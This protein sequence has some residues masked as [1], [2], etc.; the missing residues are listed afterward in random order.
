MKPRKASQ[1]VGAN[2]ERPPNALLPHWS[3]TPRSGRYWATTPPTSVPPH[4]IPGSGRAPARCGSTATTNR[5]STPLRSACLRAEVA[6]D[7]GRVDVVNG[8]PAEDEV[9]VPSHVQ[10]VTVGT[11]L[12]DGEPTA[13]PGPVVR[14]VPAVAAVAAG[15]ALPQEPGTGVGRTYGTSWH[16]QHDRRPWPMGAT[17]AAGCRGGVRTGQSAKAVA[18]AAGA[19]AVPVPKVPQERK[20]LPGLPIARGPA[21]HGPLRR[22]PLTRRGVGPRAWGRRPPAGEAGSWCA[23]PQDDPLPRQGPG[24]RDRRRQRREGPAGPGVVT[25]GFQHR[26]RRVCARRDRRS[27]AGGQC[28]GSGGRVSRHPRSRRNRS[29]RRRRSR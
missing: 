10:L 27:R 21:A 26:Q 9:P 17:P 7:L 4:C 8:H 20:V 22:Q 18:G 14:G 15:E 24:R 13:V 19:S 11:G 3:V 25:R 12:V 16:R 5:R 6:K 29:A 1:I 2:I 23:Q 28:W